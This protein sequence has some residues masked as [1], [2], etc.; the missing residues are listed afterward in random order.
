MQHSLRGER[1]GAGEVHLDAQLRLAFD[2]HG[3]CPSVMFQPEF[4]PCERVC[5][6]NQ[7]PRYFRIPCIC[8]RGGSHVVVHRNSRELGVGHPLGDK[9][10]A[11]AGSQWVSAAGCSLARSD[12][13]EG[14]KMEG[15]PP[16]IV[17]SIQAP[18]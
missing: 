4:P 10:G 8:V 12:P 15:V 9:L 17:A 16:P 2:G 18:G 6:G 11:Q 7:S 5:E 13:L 3:M 1:E 14:S